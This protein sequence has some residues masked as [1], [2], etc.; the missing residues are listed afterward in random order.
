[1]NRGLANKSVQEIKLHLTPES[2]CPSSVDRIPKTL[3]SCTD[4]NIQYVETQY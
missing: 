3:W 1:M 2:I 4:Y